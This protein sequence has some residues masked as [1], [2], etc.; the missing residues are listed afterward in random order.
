MRFQ[1]IP[2][3][4][5]LVFGWLLIPPAHLFGLQILYQG[6]IQ[7][8]MGPLSK[9]NLAAL[10]GEVDLAR[11]QNPETLLFSTGSVLGA[12]LDCQENGGQ[13][14]FSIMN[15]CGFDAMALGPHDFFA[16]F[17]NLAQRLSELQFPAVLTNV[18]FKPGT[19]KPFPD[20]ST[21][22]PYLLLNRFGKNIMV[23]G[24]IC[25]TV[26][27]DWPGWDPAVHLENPIESLEK[28]ES[29]ARK[30][31]LVI[32]LANISFRDCVVL[33]KKLHWVHLILTNP[34]GPDEVFFGESLD[35]SLRDG[36]RICWTLPGN[37]RPN[38]LG[39][40]FKNDKPYIGAA[41]PEPS[42]QA[43]DDR[44]IAQEINHS[45][46]AIGEKYSRT[47]TRLSPDEIEHSIET[48]LNA[49][50]TELGAELAILA[51][52]AFGG[53]AGKPLS[54]DLS[55]IEIRS[56]FKFPDHAALLQ[57]EG[58]TIQNLWNRRNEHLLNE[59]G[60]SLAGIREVGGRLIIN[61]RVLNPKDKYKVA[62]S[63]Y[64]ARGGFSL[65]TPDTAGLMTETIPDLL[66]RHFSLKTDARK[67]LVR[68]LE[69]KPIVKQSFSLSGSYNQQSFSSG[70][71]NYQ[72]SDPEA[73]YSGSDIPGLVGSKF[74][75]RTALMRWQGT[76]L[77][78]DYEWLSRLDSTY[79]NY[80]DYK[81]V[82]KWNFTLRYRRTSFAPEWL[83]FGEMTLAGTNL[84]P[85]VAGKSLPLFGKTV[86]GLA[87]KGDKNIHL[88]AGLGKIYRFSVDG[89]PENLG[90]NLG[91]EYTGKVLGKS[92]FN[93]MFT[94]FTSPEKDK[95]TTFEGYGELKVPIFSRLSA[96]F[97]YGVF[98]WRDST[99]G[100][101]ADRTEAFAGFSY[102]LSLRRF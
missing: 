19:G 37:P 5:L 31:D 22:K 68:R 65:F 10:K 71:A 96:Q 57:V 14:L 77:A 26:E 56:V 49:I 17:P 86:I 36:R 70:A 30:A 51:T 28:Y 63:E 80:K 62:T 91:Y 1:R 83:P 34:M 27:K 61:G 53:M 44:E 46:E 24:A 2:V 18:S 45:E 90:L 48:L 55:E 92:E 47:L 29:E 74:R 84:K 15:R 9:G 102:D 93:S 13:H 89:R 69:S 42:A 95:V 73:L 43:E 64:L 54:A 98:G 87:R 20:V 79:G 8:A 67:T 41:N 100:K 4:F 23:F 6:G 85:H 97:R 88:F 7:G 32:L 12:T 78:P 25:S 75:M 94:Y 52:S 59:T 40:Q 35:F 16:G 82:D 33:L 39:I 101:L 66:I 21:I 60:I 72:Y 38:A 50:R 99:I 81:N 11:Q 3:V 76:I 58:A